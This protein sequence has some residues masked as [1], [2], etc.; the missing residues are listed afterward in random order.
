GVV[1]WPGADTIAG[2]DLRQAVARCLAQVRAPSGAAAARRFRKALAVS[3]GSFEATEV[4]AI[5]RADAGDEECHRLLLLLLLLSYRRHGNSEPNQDRE[6]FDGLHTFLLV[7]VRG[8]AAP[9]GAVALSGRADECK[10][11]A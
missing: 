5:S 3:V 2:I 4:A 7:V 6:M 10:S 9:A 11:Q 1:P 8:L